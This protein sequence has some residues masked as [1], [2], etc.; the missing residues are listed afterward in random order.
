MNNDPAGRASAPS[1]FEIRIKGRITP[2]SQGAFE[3]LAVSISPVETVLR[4]TVVDSAALYGILDRI[5][6]LGL[7]LVEVRRGMPAPDP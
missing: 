4:G 5:Q 2:S 3:G 7:E 1:S 6:A